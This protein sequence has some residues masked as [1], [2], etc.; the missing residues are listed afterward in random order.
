MAL[1]AN[2]DAVIADLATFA[3]NKSITVEQALTIAAVRLIKR[4]AADNPNGSD[5]K[6]LIK[7]TAQ[8]LVA[9]MDA[10]VAAE[11]TAQAALVE[12]NRAVIVAA[13]TAA[14]IPE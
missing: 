9:R 2:L 3:T 6:T 12:A 1:N 8:R 7:A 13:I 11:A 10:I 4:Y 5:E 14:N